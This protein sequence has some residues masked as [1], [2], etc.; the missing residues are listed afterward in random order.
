MHGWMIVWLIDFALDWFARFIACMVDWLFRRTSVSIHH[1]INIYQLLIH[2]ILC[3]CCCCRCAS[4]VLPWMPRM[5]SSCMMLARKHRGSN[6]SSCKK[7][8][9]QM[10]YGWCKLRTNKLKPIKGIKTYHKG[11]R[12]PVKEIKVP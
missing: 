4:T 3:C 2:H 5:S 11:L 10:I 6:M 9:W 7:L 8:D 12:L 1:I